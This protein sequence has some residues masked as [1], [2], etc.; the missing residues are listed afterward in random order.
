[1]TRELINLKQS[2]TPLLLCGVVLVYKAI[3]VDR[4]LHPITGGAEYLLIFTLLLSWFF[5]L[6]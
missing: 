4:A 3:P 6:C 2:Y 1:M 5:R